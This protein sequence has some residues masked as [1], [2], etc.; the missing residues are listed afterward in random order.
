LRSEE[1]GP[2]K[3]MKGRPPQ[4]GHLQKDHIKKLKHKN[5]KTI[6]ALLTSNI[7]KLN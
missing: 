2:P 1:T 5:E 4:N 6:K 7:K 3:K